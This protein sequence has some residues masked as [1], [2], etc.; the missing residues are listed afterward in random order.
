MLPNRSKYSAWLSK[1]NES[2]GVGRKS[3]LPQSDV[4]H[5]SWG[6]KSGRP[7]EKRRFT[8]PFKSRN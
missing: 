6:A 4:P 8:T 2:H 3:K 7:Q 1:D 5:K